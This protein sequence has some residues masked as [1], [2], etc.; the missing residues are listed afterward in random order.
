MDATHN[1]DS[2]AR[3][4][5]SRRPRPGNLPAEGGAAARAER[6]NARSRGE[7]AKELE[8]RLSVKCLKLAAVLFS[9]AY[10][11]TDVLIAQRL[12]RR[13]PA[14][15][16]CNHTS[17]LDPA[18]I[19]SVCPRMIVWM[20]ASEYYEIKALTWMYNMI[21]AI[22]VD[23]SGRDM[24]ATRAALRALGNG[25]ILGIFPEGKIATSRALLPFQSGVAMLAIKTK[26][27][28]YP[29]FLDGTQR[30][31]E[32]V[33]AIAVPQEATLAFGP[34]VQVDRRR[35]SRQVMESAT[36]RIRDA[37]ETLKVATERLRWTTGV[38]P[39][40]PVQ[41]HTRPAGGSHVPL[42][43]PKGAI[44]AALGATKEIAKIFL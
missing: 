33:P 44:P 27:P 8:A 31:Q 34:P 22:P 13:G 18:L 36:A 23:R 7:P 20:M 29:A 9:R 30:G 35:T 43:A 41:G 38:P 24:A 28:V 25:R 10:H 17:G 11:R 42:G 40:D 5:T 19:Q 14:I 3:E 12:P 2:G 39:V 26:V 37:V 4:E 32:M 16:V 1:I 6:R 21:E 15:L